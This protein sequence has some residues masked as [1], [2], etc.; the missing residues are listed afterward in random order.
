MKTA[1]AV[2]PIRQNMSDL[3][4]TPAAVA[5]FFVTVAAMAAASIAPAVADALVGDNVRVRHGQ[6]WRLVTYVLTH[7]GWAHLVV[8]MLLLY[9]FVPQLE[10]LMGGARMLAVYLGC[11]VLGQTLLFAVF[12]GPSRTFGASAAL[13][14]VVG[15]LVAANATENGNLAGAI[16]VAAAL[17]GLA[18]IPALG[19]VGTLAAPGLP[20]YAFGVFVHAL[21][22][23]PGVALGF[24]LATQN[25]PRLIAVAIVI[26]A[27]AVAA[28]A[29]G[30]YRADNQMASARPDRNLL[31][32][33]TVDATR[34][35]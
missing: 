17:L 32:R 31:R 27:I 4:A 3:A 16:A 19:G 18:G 11:A 30:W 5:L 25:R 28:V 10:R 24:A 15:A 6:V 26:V 1:S 35:S 8:N 7:N 14:G 34:Q 20:G 22:L 2:L 9:L 13:F 12:P 33:H 29:I 23:I 21:G